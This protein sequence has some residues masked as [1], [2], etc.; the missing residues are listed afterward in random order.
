MIV[1][2]DTWIAMAANDTTI[3]ARRMEA[4]SLIALAR[5][6]LTNPAEEIAAIFLDHAIDA[7]QSIENGGSSGLPPPS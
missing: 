1:A 7:L 3:V 2:R 6:M 5:A 4:E